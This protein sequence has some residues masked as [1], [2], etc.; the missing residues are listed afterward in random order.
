M[1]ARV[2]ISAGPGGVLI[3]V[4]VQPRAKRARVVGP[5]GGALKIAVSEPPEEGR[6]NAA[7]VTMIANLFS[8]PTSAVEVVAGRNSRRKRL[9]LRGLN[10]DEA[11]AAIDA[12]T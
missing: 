7:A 9:L 2:T 11:K 4:H 6:A 3:N 8:L 5:Y 1:T 12:I 10:T